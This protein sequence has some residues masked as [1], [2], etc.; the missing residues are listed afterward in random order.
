MAIINDEDIITM[1]LLDLIKYENSMDEFIPSVHD[2][3]NYLTQYSSLH[4]M[5]Q[6]IKGKKV[7]DVQKILVNIFLPHLGKNNFNG[8]AFINI[9]FLTLLPFNKLGYILHFQPLQPD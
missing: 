1:C 3:G 6:F 5:A 7:R 8:L 4:Y 9:S 2:G